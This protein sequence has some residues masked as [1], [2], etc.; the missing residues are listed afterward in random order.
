MLN[1]IYVWFFR[2]ISKVTGYLSF[3]AYVLYLVLSTCRLAIS[4]LVLSVFAQILFLS[5]AIRIFILILSLSGYFLS[6][7]GLL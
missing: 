4:R 3:S 5:E 6:L 7:F 2:I 1:L